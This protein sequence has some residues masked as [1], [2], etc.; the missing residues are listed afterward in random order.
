[1]NIIRLGNRIENVQR[2]SNVGKPYLTAQ[3]L[4]QKVFNPSPDHTNVKAYYVQS[5]PTAQTP[6]F[7]ENMPKGTKELGEYE[8]LLVDK[9]LH[10]QRPILIIV[11]PMGSGKTTV[12][13]YVG[14]HL[15]KSRQYCDNCRPPRQRMIAQIDFNEHTQLNDLTGKELSNKLYEIICD[16]LLSRINHDSPVPGQDEFQ[17]FWNYELRRFNNHQSSSASFR[18]IQSSMPG[19]LVTEKELSDEEIYVRKRVLNTIRKDKDIHL[20][21]LLRLWSFVNKSYYCGNHGCAFVILDNLDIVHPMV[22]RKIVETV[23]THSQREGPTFLLLLRPETFDKL[24]MGT[25]I[26]DVETHRGTT[27]S[28]IILMRLQ[29]F[30]DNP[31][32]YFEPNGGLTRE[33]FE[34]VKRYV[35][36]VNQLVRNDHNQSFIK[37]IN[38][39]CG[40]SIRSAFLIAQNI[41][42]ASIAEMNDEVLHAR[43]I[44]R[45][46]IRGDEPQL[47][48]TPEIGVEHLFRV[49]PHEIG[50]LMIKPRILHYLERTEKGRRRINEITNT[51][52]A[53]G[54]EENIVLDAMNDMMQIKHQ[55]IRSNGFDHYEDEALKKYSSDRV[56]ITD[57][58]KGYI[59]RLMYD[60]DYLQEVMLDTYVDGD[61][62]P[63]SISYG[64]LIDKFRLIR[65]FLEEIRRTDVEE[66]QRFLEKLPDDS[67]F[68]AF[69][70]HI[71]SL[72]II[73][74]IYKPATRIL[75]SVSRDSYEYDELID[76]FKSLALKVEA[77]NKKLLGG[78]WVESVVQDYNDE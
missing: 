20:D 54:F 33:Q 66:M 74:A 55:L 28:D 68:R 26:L 44:I 64:Y 23:M 10:P 17:K 1:M 40:I 31:E 62:F 78:K 25:G 8:V 35:K 51:M 65:L 76:Q 32:E 3:Y 14:L 12:K 16:E 38:D 73:H 5:Q 67:Y 59:N 50:C 36:R 56:L 63:K 75:R 24:G 61:H 13:N 49:S 43:D 21:Y 6:P 52:A 77:D 2:P 48:W 57:I 45:I 29:E 47:H 18:K 46:C 9:L 53:F 11:G 37:F 4:A 15:V 39:A 41:F 19:D 27:P 58:G 60:I 69:G 30:C 70:N 71:I 34:T 7:M 22:Q 42:S 72:E